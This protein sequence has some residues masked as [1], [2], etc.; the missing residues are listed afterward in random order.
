MQNNKSVRTKYDYLR[1]YRS[2]E[3]S[4]LF[5]V[6]KIKAQLA[7]KLS[8]ESLHSQVIVMSKQS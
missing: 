3:Y 1:P 8:I 4:E 5:L 2:F 6:A 7:S